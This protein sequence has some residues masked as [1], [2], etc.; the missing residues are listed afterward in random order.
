MLSENPDLGAHFPEAST[1]QWAQLVEKIMKGRSVDSLIKTSDEG[2]PIRPLYT[3]SSA[4]LGSAWPD[5]VPFTR[6]SRVLDRRKAGWEICQLYDLGELSF[7]K[8]RM[9]KDLAR[10]VHSVWVKISDGHQAGLNIYNLKTL[11]NFFSDVDLRSVPVILDGGKYAWS[12]FASWFD[13]TRELGCPA[14]ELSGAILFDPLAELLRSGSI[15][16]MD[17]AI[18]DLSHAVKLREANFPELKLIS[19]SG[20]E[21]HNAGAHGA[22]ELGFVCASLVYYLRELESRGLPLELIVP[23][24]QARLGLGRDMFTEIAKVRALR[25]LWSRVLD[26]CG[27]EKELQQVPIHGVCSSSTQSRRDPWVNMLRST[28]EAFAGTVAGVDTLTVLPFDRSLGAPSSLGYRMSGNLQVLLAEEAHLGR[29]ADPSGGSWFL[30]ELTKALCENAWDFFQSIEKQGGVLEALKSGFITTE[31]SKVVSERRKQVSL[32]KSAIVGVSEFPESADLLARPTPQRSLLSCAT[33]KSE[34]AGTF[35]DESFK[36]MMATLKLNSVGHYSFEDVFEMR[37]KGLTT[38]MPELPPFRWAEDWEGL[39]EWSDRHLETTGQRPQ[40]FLAKMGPLRDHK[41]RAAFAE[42]FFL[43]GG[44]EVLGDDGFETASES[45]K[46]LKDLSGSSIGV[47]LCGKDS[48]YERWA[49]EWANAFHSEK[50][51]FIA[52]AGSPGE[53]EKTWREAGVSHFVHLGCDGIAIL[54]ELLKNVEA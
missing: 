42:R 34:A 53:H 25:A 29:V 39:R 17:G 1:E 46:H 13:I 50:V 23:A 28:S 41:A 48:D 14:Q 40:V 2:V 49:E 38:N 22:Q 45:L 37:R 32:R 12:L 54:S 31:V 30:E 5:E 35:S 47:I 10:G 21:L 20:L 52:L 15:E 7:F 11:R 24:M 6:G 9:T 26:Q 36:R 18:D 3:Q 43:A 51:P 27:L 4:S 19:V 33:E 44:F 16:D 8:D